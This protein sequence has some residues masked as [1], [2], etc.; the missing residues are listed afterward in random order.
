M[1]AYRYREVKSGH[2]NTQTAELQ[3]GPGEDVFV[4]IPDK[5]AGNPNRLLVYLG[6]KPFAQADLARIMGKFGLV[7]SK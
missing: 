3:I 1:K 7:P 4:P 2:A 5:I 6:F